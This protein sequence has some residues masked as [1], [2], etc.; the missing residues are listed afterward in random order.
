MR[1]G[2]GGG[3]EKEEWDEIEEERDERRGKGMEENV[4]EGKNTHTQSWK[5]IRK[6]KTTKQD[7]GYTVF[8]Y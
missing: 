7:L 5:Q 2:K 6:T 4:E 8:I 3:R 1:E